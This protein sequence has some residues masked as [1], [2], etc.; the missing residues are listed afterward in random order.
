M[1]NDALLSSLID[2]NVNMKWNIERVRNQGHTP[3]FATLW[4]KGAC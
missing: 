1:R 4:G 2:S 3:W